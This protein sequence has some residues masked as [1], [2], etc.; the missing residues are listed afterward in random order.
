VIRDTLYRPSGAF[1]NI[2]YKMKE[3]IMRFEGQV[4]IV[5]GGVG[6]LGKGIVGR[7]AS[8]GGAGCGF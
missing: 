5:T 3:R 8:E 2:T 7:L 6:G 1:V 4:A